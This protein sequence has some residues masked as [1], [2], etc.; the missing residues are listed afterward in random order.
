MFTA[1]N[2][3]FAATVEEAYET[4]HKNKAN[5]ILGGCCWLPLG[6]KR[7]WTAIDLTRL[8][9]DKIE[10]TQDWV[11][12][13]AMVTLRQLETSPVL[14]RLAGGILSQSVKGIVGVQFRNSATIGGSVWMRA[15]FS[16]PLTVLLA[17]DTTVCFHHSGEMPLEEFMGKPYFKD[18]L[19]HVKIRREGREGAYES[20]RNTETDFPVLTAA[21][22]RKGEDWRVVVGSRPGRAVLA[23]EAA[24]LLKAGDLEGAC[25][26]VAEELPFGD[27]LRASGEY[28]RAIAPVLVRRA[29]EK[30]LKGEGQA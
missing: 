5:Q 3:S 25:A 15:S 30:I 23:H 13:G 12:L 27:N 16:D 8:G 22:T 21:V 29:A 28:R 20:L 24:R 9:L 4:L 11:E 18:I 19:T 10:E 1:K 14:N 26:S 6:K 2:Y 7:I 17:M